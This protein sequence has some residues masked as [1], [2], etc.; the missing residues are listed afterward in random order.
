MN[1]TVKIFANRSQTL[2]EDQELFISAPFVSR[3]VKGVNYQSEIALTAAL[4]LLTLC[5][6][7]LFFFDASG[8]LL[9]RIRGEDFLGTTEQVF[10][11]LIIFCLIYGNLL[12]QFTRW[13]Y[14]K[15][16]ATYQPARQEELASLFDK[17]PPSL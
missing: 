4:I 9:N 13:G 2:K 1:Q 12:Y 16:S 11:I 8:I 10:F 7:V 6:S 17:E 14:L 5:A 15:R 3:E